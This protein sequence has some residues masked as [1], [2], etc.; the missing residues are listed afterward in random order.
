M[1]AL[2]VRVALLAAGLGLTE[3]GLLAAMGAGQ[4]SGWAMT[5]L[6]GLPLLIAGT[7]GIIHP[8]LKGGRR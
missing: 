7:A 6:V 8:L 3:M 1:T 5:L 4:A 2:L